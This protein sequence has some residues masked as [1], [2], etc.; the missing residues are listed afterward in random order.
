MG[1][2][3]EPSN[4]NDDRSERSGISCAPLHEGADR[5]RRGV[6]DRHLVLL[7]HPPPPTLV[8]G[9]RGALV[10]ER[11]R[12]IRQRPVDDVAVPGDP[13]DVRGAPVQ[14][15]VG[16]EVEHRPMG[17]RHLGQVAARRV[18]DSLRLAGGARGVHDVQ[19]V[20]R[21]EELALVLGG[22]LLDDVV[23]PHVTAV[24]PVDVLTRTADHQHG[25]DIRTALQ[26]VVDRGLQRGGGPAAVTAVGGDHHVGVAIQDPVGQG[27]AGEP[28]EHH[29]VRGAQPGAGQHR[30]H[31]LRDHRHVD[32]DPVTG[33]DPEFDQCVGGLGDLVLELGVGDGPGVAGLALPLVGD[34][35][36]GSRLDVAVHAVVRHVE[37]AADEPLRERLVRPVQNLGPALRPAQPLGLLLPEREPVG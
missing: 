32:G 26:G 37:L 22:L 25:R 14:V 31:R 18:Q 9:I 12:R 17:V 13:T 20:L 16:L 21:V 4:R 3:T 6:Q 36:T 8:R 1:S 28:P 10:H 35:V 7:D 15:G 24:C 29:G 30:D 23:P 2:P 5:G 19:R 27:L 34:L 33:L 11:G